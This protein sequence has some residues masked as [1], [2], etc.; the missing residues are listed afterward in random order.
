MPLE[1]QSYDKDTQTAPEPKGRQ[2]KAADMTGTRGQSIPK[3]RLPV[4]EV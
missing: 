4:T 3:T 2:R 1:I